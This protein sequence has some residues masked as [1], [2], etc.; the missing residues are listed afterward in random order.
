MKKRF[1]GLLLCL[2]MITSLFAGMSITAGA[3]GIVTMSSLTSDSGVTFTDASDG[4]TVTISS[5]EELYYLASYANAGRTTSG[6]TWLLTA[7]IA[8]NDETF[9][10]DADT[11]LVTVTDGVYTAYLGTGIKGDGSGVNDVF[12]TTASTARVWYASD[13]S[14]VFG[15]TYDGD[16]NAWTPISW[17]SFY[18]NGVFN[19]DGHTISGLYINTANTFQ[20]LFG[21]LNGQVKDF[22]ITGAWVTATSYV[23]AV[24]GSLKGGSIEDVTV[25]ESYV[26]GADHAGGITGQAYSASGVAVT[27]SNASVA[28]SIVN[29]GSGSYIAGIVGDAA[30]S[31]IVNCSADSG[32]MVIG[33]N[34]VGGTAGYNQGNVTNCANLASVHGSAYVGGIVGTNANGSV[35]NVYST[36]SVTASTSFG[37]IS[38]SVRSG[39][40][41]A[42][43]YWLSG[44]M[45]GG[46]YAGIANYI[47]SGAGT[48]SSPVTVNSISCADLSAALNAWVAM[49]NSALY[50][51][52]TAGASPIPSELYAVKT[53]TGVTY[54][55]GA[56]TYTA[57]ASG[58]P[59]AYQWY[60][61]T[62][63]EATDV[64]AN[65]FGAYTIS[66]SVT[67]TNFTGG[68]SSFNDW[69]N[70]D[71]VWKSGN[72]AGSTYSA[73]LMKVSVTDKDS[74][75]ITFETRVSSE[76]GCDKLSFALFTLGGT[77]LT[78]V[79]DTYTSIS[80]E[81][82]WASYSYP[83]GLD[84]DY[85]ILFAY[86]KDGGS[87]VG[88]DA[89]FVRLAGLNAAD[90]AANATI[91][92]SGLDASDKVRC[93][94]S[95]ADGTKIATA[96]FS[97]GGYP[98]TYY[99]QGDSD[100]IA[101]SGNAIAS[102]Y[103]TYFYGGLSLP[104]PTKSG[105]TFGG[106]F[107]S[108]DG[109][110]QVSSIGAGD[111]GA[112]TFYAKWIQGSPVVDVDDSV[113]ASV[114]GGSF[115]IGT[116]SVSG[117]ST[118]VTV[119]Q[120][121]FENVLDLAGQNG[122]IVI[123]V[124][125]MRS[126]STA[127]L[128]VKNIE[129]AAAQGVTISVFSGGVTYSLDAADIDTQAILA[130]LGATDSGDVTFTVSIKR[131]DA[132]TSASA[133]AAV[134]IDGAVMVAGP[135]EFTVTA[136]YGGRTYSVT[137]FGG[138]MTRSIEITAE[139]AESITSA[140]IYRADGTYYQA[141]TNIRTQTDG[142]GTI[143]YYADVA[144][145][146]DSVYVLIHQEK[147]FADAEGTWY[148]DAVNEMA[149]RAIVGGDGDGMFYGQ[150]SITRA[151]FAAIV[152]RALGLESLYSTA[153]DKFADVS[154][155]A[156]YYSDVGLACSFGIVTGTTDTVF[157]PNRN[158]TRQEAMVMIARACAI[159][160]LA[161]GSE[162]YSTLTGLGE[163][164]SWALD[165]VIFNLK[166]G[167]I[168]G[169]SSGFI[170]SKSDIT[171]A[172]SVVI[173]LR[174]MQRSDLF[175]VRAQA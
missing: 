139:Q 154:K 11:G 113:R 126:T 175:D 147:S 102:S 26:S 107:T 35:Q 49:I 155:D 34:Y 2:S 83:V 77:E 40:I 121:Q 42:N 46:G 48:F 33:G 16:L 84:G 140:V 13:D 106:W 39:G 52:W 112:K 62:G 94:V 27:V 23:G 54:D 53:I 142:N 172:E 7:D 19:G 122:E 110:E 58:T 148:K 95:Y 144:S 9:V 61:F 97:A 36:G 17:N 43:A 171:R 41:V 141:P 151:E 130:G 103:Y 28:G 4:D 37:S 65:P 114:G 162:D 119:N 5:E 111:T 169:N 165:A 89:G 22:S 80:G 59:S 12:D 31:E 134:T 150:K 20:G 120:N 136:T 85:Y 29:G 93:S 74:E 56:Q 157:E 129:D 109:T 145:L 1:L 78:Y 164:S 128:I 47:L 153:A 146:H 125:N 73:M 24:A 167:L 92:V 44:S 6:I 87:S 100:A 55:S 60:K 30:L 115:I 66:G 127:S 82:D 135:V 170:D 168:Q 98:I 149:S 99:D 38:G 143:R 86:S 173:V 152:V 137:N 32:T 108:F 79:D 131:S 69:S 75:Q 15:E 68:F 14:A 70:T 10:F 51:G 8:L 64:S 25:S 159:T 88:E 117:G 104:T 71:M 118:T 158:I 18:F 123:P 63:V 76:P 138:F 116:Q 57:A 96:N 101:F 160:Q 3:A 67:A 132:A 124:G 163:V 91:D 50:N 45:D 161:E 105:F 174:M 90:A 81:T 72:S 21:S 156:W 133:G 166:T